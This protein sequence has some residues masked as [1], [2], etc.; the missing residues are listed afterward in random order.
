MLIF[1]KIDNSTR[2]NS[3]YRML[4]TA[5]TLKEPLTFVERNTAHREYLSI[6]LTDL[7]WFIIKN[8]IKIFEVFVRPSVKLQGE[9]YVTLPTALVYI[10]KVYTEL[11]TLKEYF[12]RQATRDP[13][14]VS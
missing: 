14:A 5:Y 3:T 2:W 7:D 4:L 10:Y 9:I 6:A 13:S 1:I 12:A 11:S 8:L